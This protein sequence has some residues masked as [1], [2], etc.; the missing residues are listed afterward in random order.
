MRD[1]SE[2]AAG[3][4]QEQPVLPSRGAAGAGPSAGPGAPAGTGDGDIGNDR[5][6]QAKHLKP[7]TQNQPLSGDKMS[8]AHV[9]SQN[10]LQEGISLNLRFAA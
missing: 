10:Q 1:V 6:Q 8:S 5:I 7:Q 4:G 9:K 2:E 3:A